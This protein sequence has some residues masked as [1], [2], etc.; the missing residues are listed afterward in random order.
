MLYVILRGEFLNTICMKQVSKRI[1][2]KRIEEK[3]WFWMEW[4][5]SIYSTS[6]FKLHS[7]LIQYYLFLILFDVCCLYN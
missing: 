6:W 3:E 5:E 7:I 1:V 2:L 4:E